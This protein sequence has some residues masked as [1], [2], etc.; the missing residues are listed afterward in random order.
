MFYYPG[1]HESFKLNNELIIKAKF[2][3]VSVQQNEVIKKQK[4]TLVTSLIS[5]INSLTNIS[6]YI[7]KN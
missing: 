2:H 6:I 1:I 5:F 4:Q 7:N 3:R